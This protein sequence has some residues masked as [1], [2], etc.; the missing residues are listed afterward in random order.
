[1]QGNENRD[2]IMKRLLSIDDNGQGLDEILNLLR[3]H[4]YAA[5]EVADE[6]PRRDLACVQRMVRNAPIVIYGV[7]R[8]GIFTLSEGKG[9]SGMGLKPG[10]VVGRSAFDVYRDHPECMD[11]FHRALAG[12]AFTVQVHFGA[13]V[14]DAYHEPVFGEN[15]AYAGTFGVLVDVTERTRAEEELRESEEKF[16]VLAET[17]PAAIALYQGE[18]VIYINPTAARLIGYTVEELSRICF[19]GCVHDD[20]KEMVQERGLAR[21]RGEPVPGQYECRFVTKDG[22]ELWAIISVGRIEF[23]GK[24][25]GIVTL[26]D[27]TEAKLA[28]EKMRTSLAEKVVLLKEVHHRV[29]NNLQIIS[30]LLEL[31]SDSIV[32]EQS[33][34]FISESQ[35]RIRSIALVHEQLYR[36]TNLS[37]IDFACYVGELV[38]SLCRSS[39]RDPER[40]RVK[41][42]IRNIEL[43]IDEAIPCGLIINELVSNSLKH[44][45]PGDREGEILIRAARD[46][47][48]GVR[49]SVADTGVGLSPGINLLD[50]E[51]LGLQ[52]VSLL[53][54]QLHG[55]M[56]ILG[57]HGVTVTVRFPEKA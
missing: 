5:Q 14:Y 20:F 35:D 39:L 18:E 7:D 4:G 26:I 45:F 13:H 6:L 34:R 43:G 23:K 9:L 33:R 50:T 24:P 36:S 21:M 8:Q 32:E 46:G 16:R 1:M 29:K 28:D 54:R 41:L 17:S 56:E 37:F 49:L 19:W 2:D 51:T 40:I 12:E 22:N 15:G 38:D 30:S 10:E 48:G 27:T 31:Q 53:T 44:A 42:E 57:D 11:N 55:T 25:A 47:E 3:E 52:I